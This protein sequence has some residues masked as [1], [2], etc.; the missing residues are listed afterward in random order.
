MPSRKAKK[1]NLSSAL[2]ESAVLARH[3]PAL[4][5]LPQA[6]NAAFP[7]Q[8]GPRHRCVVDLLAR[9]PIHRPARILAGGK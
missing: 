2:T 8:T 5:I 7:G 3:F 4:G 1:T 6:M 9:A